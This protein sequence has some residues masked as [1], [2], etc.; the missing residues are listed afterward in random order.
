M[1]QMIETA[2]RDVLVG[3][4]LLYFKCSSL[5]VMCSLDA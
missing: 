3:L 1:H 4:D 5:K 2:E